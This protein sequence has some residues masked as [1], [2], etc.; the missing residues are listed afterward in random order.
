MDPLRTRLQVAL[1][2]LEQTAQTLAE[3]ALELE[4]GCREPQDKLLR[5]YYARAY[6]NLRDS[7]QELRV[8]AARRR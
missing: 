7:L 1:G 3:A 5:D 2:D 8:L 6:L 4:Y